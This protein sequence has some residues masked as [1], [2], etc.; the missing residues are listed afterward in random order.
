MNYIQRQ[1]GF[2]TNVNISDA[3]YFHFIVML[4]VCLYVSFVSCVVTITT[5]GLAVV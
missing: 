1:A 4:C 5:Q 3:V 2:H